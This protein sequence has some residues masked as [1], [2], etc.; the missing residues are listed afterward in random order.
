MEASSTSSAACEPSDE[1]D[2]TGLH[3][4]GRQLAIKR[5]RSAATAGFMVGFKKIALKA[6][7]E[8]QKRREV[9][10]PRK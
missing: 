2:A 5:C 10:F 6:A 9:D 4:Q 1:E 8:R 7:R 3:A